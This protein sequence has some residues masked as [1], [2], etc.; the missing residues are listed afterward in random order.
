MHEELDERLNLLSFDPPTD[1]EGSPTIETIAF[2]AFGSIC[3]LISTLDVLACACCSTS[4]CKMAAAVLARS[5]TLRL[6]QTSVAG[7]KVLW[8]A[9]VRMNGAAAAIDVSGCTNLD[10]ASLIRSVAASPQLQLLRACGIGKGSW[11]TASLGR[12]LH[13]TKS[14]ALLRVIEADVRLSLGARRSVQ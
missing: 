12:L 5:R 9:R 7:H 6:P 3:S 4:L 1:V 10:R 14:H 8:L 2:D 11:T 13:A